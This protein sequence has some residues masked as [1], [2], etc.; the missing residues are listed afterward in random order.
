M[1]CKVF[2]SWVADA[3]FVW[4]RCFISCVQA[5]HQTSMVKRIAGHVRRSS[6]L[7]N[8]NSS[9]VCD[10][11]VYGTKH[12]ERLASHQPFAATNSQRSAVCRSANRLVLSRQREMGY[13][14]ATVP[15]VPGTRGMFAICVG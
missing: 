7:T 5:I 3:M 2:V 15:D 13:R 10:R 14:Q 6:A 8:E 9:I 4:Q 12:I 1:D 11:N